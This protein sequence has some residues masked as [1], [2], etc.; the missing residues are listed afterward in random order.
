MKNSD[1]KRG[2]EGTGP[3]DLL[4]DGRGAEGAAERGIA[5]VV[6]LVLSAVVLAVITTVIYMIT[7]GTQISG[8]QKQYRTAQEAAT[9]GSD[10]FYKII[11]TRGDT[12]TFT[13]VTISVPP[14]TS[15]TGTDSSGVGYSGFKT[16]LMVDSSK[17]SPGCNA[18]DLTIDPTKSNT[19]DLMISGLGSYEYFAKIVATVAGNS[20]AAASGGEGG[21]SSTLLYQGSVV[22]N[23]VAGGSGSGSGGSVI[24]VVSKPYLYAIEV[25]TRNTTNPTER[26]RVSIL[27]QY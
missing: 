10:L 26:A 25:Y 22:T 8:M 19:Y 1:G 16:K 23:G 6:V 18:N 3:V 27:Y 17:W 13:Q 15:C 11:A 14:A 5:L 12:S 20:A 21:G 4:P 2:R 9:G 7:A 24:P